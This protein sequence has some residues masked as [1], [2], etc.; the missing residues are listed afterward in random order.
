MKWLRKFSTM[1]K[2]LILVLTMNVLLLIVAYTGYSTSRTIV[3][4]MNSM[5]TEY[6][7]PAISMSKMESMAI[8]NRRMIMNMFIFEDHELVAD[9]EKRILENRKKIDEAIEQFESLASDQEE[10]TLIAELRRAEK[11]LFAKR[12]EA[13]GV[14]KKP[15]SEMPEGFLLRLVGSGD[16]A[17]A[18]GEYI[19]IVERIVKLL[20]DDCEQ[21]DLWA[22]EEGRAG[23]WEIVVTSVAAI[24]FALILGALIAHSIIAP[25]KKIRN[26]I[27]L[28]REGDIVSPFP[29]EGKDEIAVMGSELQGMAEKLDDIIVSI[30]EAS[31][32]INVT[33]V[34]I[35]AI[36][37]ETN[38][39]VEEFK[40][41]VETMGKNLDILASA[42][43]EVN[44]SVREVAIGANTTAEKGTSIAGRV[45]S[46]AE[47]GDGGMASVR[48]AAR[49]I[50][51]VAKNASE[52]AKS[53][54]ELG[55][56]IRKIQG[57]VSQIGGI[58]DQTNL[59]ALNAAIEAARAGEAGRGFSV[60][61]EE[62]RKLAEESNVAAKS[63]ADLASGITKDLET[64]E[65]MSLEN[66]KGSEGASALSNE[67]EQ[68]I[69]TMLD[70]LREISTA[71]QD[72]AA[73]SEEQ[74]ASSEEI[75][76]A[77]QDIST[78]VLST[79]DASDKVRTG[80][81]DIASAS[82]RMAVNAETLSGLATKMNNT[83]AFFKTDGSSLK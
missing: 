6:A 68:V 75:S 23:T 3:G 74:A 17:A 64:V 61:A 11:S 70:Y 21:R 16:I 49:E 22:N 41:G 7:K 69:G 12:D 4:I 39:T 56:R 28:F 55:T 44:A 62:V 73:I 46:A 63:I 32:E 45:D 54:E 79:A 59:L 57:F 30:K 40:A 76:S 65:N 51:S 42:G 80:T 83:M 26:R 66:A 78:K 29:S 14:A 8:Q 24:A 5:F 27:A 25:V 53:V 19:E 58:A 71:T 34:E 60:V 72:L 50:Q 33:A 43:E 20:T 9:Y 10:K 81:E 36:A 82:E 48:N 13:I 47:A 18:E 52:A 67:T 31:E 1:S 2:I 77:V 15:H 38:A 35:S 37:E